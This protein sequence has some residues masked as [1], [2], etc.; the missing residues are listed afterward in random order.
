[1]GSLFLETGVLLLDRGTM[2]YFGANIPI[3]LI[4]VVIVEVN[5]VGGDPCWWSIILRSNIIWIGSYSHSSL[6]LFHLE[7]KELILCRL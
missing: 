1:M 5:I 6:V 3:N 4:V 7:L 2:W